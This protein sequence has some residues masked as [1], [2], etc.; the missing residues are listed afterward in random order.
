MKWSDVDIRSLS[1]AKLDISQR[2]YEVLK[3]QVKTL[4][5]LE[6]NYYQ[7]NEWCLDI[8]RSISKRP[9]DWN[10]AVVEDA[11]YAQMERELC[12]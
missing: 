3:K 10:L 7:N 5:E 6:V 2:I 1:G 4:E 8:A 12:C 11:A 9:K